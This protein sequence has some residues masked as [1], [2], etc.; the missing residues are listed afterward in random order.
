MV[1]WNTAGLTEE[2]QSSKRV[3]HCPFLFWFS[4]RCCIVRG[5]LHAI[6][7]SFR[8]SCEN[9]RGSGWV[10]CDLHLLLR[11]GFAIFLL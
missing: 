6:L 1:E 11:G 10:L 9:L 2:A 4:V 7:S 3:L 8:L 5:F